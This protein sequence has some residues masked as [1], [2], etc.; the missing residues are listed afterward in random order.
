MPW[1][2][3]SDGHFTHVPLVLT[4]VSQASSSSSS[5]N[6]IIQSGIANGHV[7]TFAGPGPSG[8]PQATL[9]LATDCSQVVGISTANG[10]VKRGWA[11]VVPSKRRIPLSGIYSRDVNGVSD[12]SVAIL[13]S[14]DN[15]FIICRTADSDLVALRQRFDA[16]VT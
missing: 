16:L 14:Q 1:N 2:K 3:S 13:V 12:G 15:S 9:G 8:W 4:H 11:W 6:D 10:T 7:L 5:T